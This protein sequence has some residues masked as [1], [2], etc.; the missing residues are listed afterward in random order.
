MG[1][2]TRVRVEETELYRSWINSLQKKDIETAI[3]LAKHIGE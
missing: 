2:T 3:D 1:Y